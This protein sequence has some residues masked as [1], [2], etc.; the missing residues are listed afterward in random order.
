MLSPPKNIKALKLNIRPS[1]LIAVLLTIT[2]LTFQTVLKLPFAELD[3][4]TYVNLNIAIHNLNWISIKH[5]LLQPMIYYMPVTWISHMLD[6]HIYKELAYGHHLTNLII[7]IFNTLLFFLINKYILKNCLKKQNKTIINWLSFFATLL[8]SIHPLRVESVAWIANRKGLMASFWSLLTVLSYL[9]YPP[10]NWRSQLS[11]TVL[12]ILAVAS[13]PSAITLPLSLLILDFL[14]IKDKGRKLIN[15]LIKKTLIRSHLY[16][17]S[18]ATSLITI[19]EHINIR[20]IDI[21][22]GNESILNIT[23]NSLSRLFFYIEKTFIPKKLTS[24]YPYIKTSWNDPKV[25]LIAT[26]LIIIF[27]SPKADKKIKAATLHLIITLLPVLGFVQSGYLSHGDR[28]SYFST[29]PL[30][31]LVT[32]AY[33]HLWKKINKKYL[34]GSLPLVIFIILFVIT[35]KQINIWESS[36]TLYT[37]SSKYYPNQSPHI[38]HGLAQVYINEGNVKKSIEIYKQSLKKFPGIKSNV[39]GLANAYSIQGDY[40]KTIDLLQPIINKNCSI[41]QVEITLAKAYLEKKEYKKCLMYSEKITK[42]YS[43]STYINKQIYITALTLQGRS[44]ENLNNERQA[45]IKYIE[46]YNKDTSNYYNLNL[47]CQLLYK[48]KKFNSLLLIIENKLKI[49]KYNIKSLLISIEY[50]KKITKETKNQVFNKRKN[51]LI[52]KLKKIKKKKIHV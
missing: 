39:L 17:L 9:K 51:E 32:G 7:H 4:R 13:H 22:K 41:P 35:Q 52:K 20:A 11:I 37:T 19:R 27:I 1:I 18:I 33:Y 23:A 26:V 44:Y 10:Q 28:W 46:A 14:F 25:I 8:W 15:K 40:D 49:D 38:Q 50:Y 30:Y 47:I 21:S 6:W 29:A 5:V 12:F 24:I 43:R 31:L 34:V 48:Q 2:T 42:A 36:K 16:L 3:T 45:L